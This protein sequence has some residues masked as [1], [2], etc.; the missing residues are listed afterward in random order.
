MQPYANRVSTRLA[1]ELGMRSYRVQ[2]AVVAAMFQLMG[3]LLEAASRADRELQQEIA[4]FPEGYTIGFAV[5]G[6]T[7]CMRLCVKDGRFERLVG[8]SA[9]PALEVVFK[10]VS[11]A[12]LVVTF[13][14]STAIAF[15]HERA[16]S[17][18]DTAL[19]MRF[20]RCLNRMQ[21]LTLPAPIVERALKRP[22]PALPLRE[23]LALG[24]KVYAQLALT[25]LERSA[26]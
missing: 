2:R 25:M 26:A 14:E 16:I 13:Q 1:S 8:E 22:L 3:R 21:A 23:K 18:G 17:H 7:L 10:H 19:G 6:D 4:G 20:V 9:R 15:A 5:L 24:S 12:F 11:H